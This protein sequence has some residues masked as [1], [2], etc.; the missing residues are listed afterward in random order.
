[1]ENMKNFVK[2]NEKGI[3]LLTNAAGVCAG[4]AVYKLVKSRVFNVVWH[5]NGGFVRTGVTVVS[6]YAAIVA[7]TA[8]RNKFREVHKVLKSILAEEENK[9]D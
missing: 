5:M 8:I 9:E 6:A 4:A 2:E 7:G 3:N 1:M